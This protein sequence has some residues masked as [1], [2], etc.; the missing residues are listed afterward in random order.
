[1]PRA[2]DA[3]PYR[4]RLPTAFRVGTGRVTARPLLLRGAQVWKGFLD[5][6]NQESLL[7]RLREVVRVAPF[8]T[9]VTPSGKAMSVRMTAAGDFGWVTDRAGY[10]YDR[11]HPNGQP[12]PAIP[13]D[14]LDVWKAVA[15]EARM[16][17]CCLV[18]FYGD[19]ARMGLHQDRDEEDFSQPVVSISLGDP[20]LFRIG[21]RTRGGATESIWLESGDVLS[22]GGDARL[23]YHGVD[24]IRFGAS[25][26]LPQGGRINLTLRVVTPPAQGA[27]VQHP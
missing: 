21:N 18:N 13:Q 3:G 10:R 1:M 25:R 16:P 12:W 11:T 14:I 19:G 6:A 22:M 2:G 4:P 5:P 24:R 17:E 27:S 26:L 7:A 9:P 15:P 20:A 8:F 23:L